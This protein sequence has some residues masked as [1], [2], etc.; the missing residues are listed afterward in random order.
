MPIGGSTG[1]GGF[2]PLV[3]ELAEALTATSAFL[4]ACEHIMA[5]GDTADHVKVRQ[6]IGF[7]LVQTNRASKV[8]EQL[9][10]IANHEREPSS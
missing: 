9:R 6:A 5:R 1:V 3:H 8:V 10:S 7:A 2:D 4:L